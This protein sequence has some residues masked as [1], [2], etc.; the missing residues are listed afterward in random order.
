MDLFA[1]LPALL[2]VSPSVPTVCGLCRSNV[3]A[4]SGAHYAARDGDY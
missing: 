1:R 3:I 4:Y 2:V